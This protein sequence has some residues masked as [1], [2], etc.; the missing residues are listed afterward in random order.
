ME[1]VSLAERLRALGATRVETKS[2]GSSIFGTGR[3][4]VRFSKTDLTT[5]Q[6]GTPLPSPAPVP[7][8][9]SKSS[10][11]NVSFTQLPTGGA[12]PKATPLQRSVSP[13]VLSPLPTP[14]PASAPTVQPQQAQQQLHAQPQQPPPQQQPTPVSAVPAVA[15]EEVI[16][17]A[18]GSPKPD[19]RGSVGDVSSPLGKPKAGGTFHVNRIPLSDKLQT[20]LSTLVEETNTLLVLTINIDKNSIDLKRK[21]LCPLAAQHII[22]HME[23]DEP[24][25][26]LVKAEY[27]V[28]FYCCPS[29]SSRVARMLYLTTKSHVL[30]KLLEFGI[31][32]NVKF[33]LSDASDLVDSDLEFQP[34]PADDQTEETKPASRPKSLVQEG[35]L[36]A[37]IVG[38]LGREHKRLTEDETAPSDE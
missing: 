36:S 23:T 25:Y 28:F 29:A 3:G 33:E 19:P 30:E 18:P 14:T 38:T 4:S 6:Q 21:V 22:P 12:D 11:S 24:A 31:E 34:W 17:Q 26:Y 7:T 20:G 9:L 13:A 5:S 8:K 10:L 32:P 15:R 35:S 1:E 16:A 2:E 37:F 27:F